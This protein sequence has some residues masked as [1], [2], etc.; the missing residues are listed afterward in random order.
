MM[1]DAVLAAHDHDY[2]RYTRYVSFQ[3]KEVKIPFIVAGDGGHGLTPRLKKVEGSRTGFIV[4][5]ITLSWGYRCLIVR[6][7]STGHYGDD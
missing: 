2:Q 3:G 5:M 1:P 6:Q 4:A 7:Q